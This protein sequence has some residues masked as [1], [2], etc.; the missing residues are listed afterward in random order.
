MSRSKLRLSAAFLSLAL[1]AGLFVAA[2]PAARAQGAPHT[3]RLLTLAPGDTLDG[4]LAT[5]GVDAADAQA[6]IDALAPLV[7]PRALQPGQKLTLD[8]SG[9]TLSELRLAIAVDRDIVVARTGGASFAAQPRRRPLTRVPEL[10]A[11]VIRT[12]LFAAAQ[13]AGVPRHVLTAMIRAFS[14]DVDFQRKSWPRSWT[15]SPAPWSRGSLPP[16]RPGA[17]NDGS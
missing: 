7:P 10:A 16:P 14:Y 4:V 13:D 6:A 5:A 11:G 17:G 8:F 12:S 9:A 15:S 3:T 1:V 2:L